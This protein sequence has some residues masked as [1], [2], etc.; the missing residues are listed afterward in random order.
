MWT[1]ASVTASLL[2]HAKRRANDGT[3]R[4]SSELRKSLTSLDTCLRAAEESAVVRA[5]TVKQL[6]NKVKSFEE[7]RKY[8]ARQRGKKYYPWRFADDFKIHSSCRSATSEVARRITEIYTDCI[9]KGE[10]LTARE[11]WFPQ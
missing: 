4:C 9:W 6:N 8:I 5:Y 1:L 11:L 3:E 7:L 10:A 2:A